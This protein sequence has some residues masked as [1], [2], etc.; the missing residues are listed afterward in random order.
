MVIE[1]HVVGKGNRVSDWW[2][3]TAGR[4]AVEGATMEVR[5]GDS[6]DIQEHMLEHEWASTPEPEHRAQQ[7]SM[8]GVDR[9]GAHEAVHDPGLG[10]EILV[11]SGLISER[12][13]RT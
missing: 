12:N 9:D 10:W 3:L 6:S 11:N 2:M 7:G 5:Q 8:S 13:T 4:S 1:K